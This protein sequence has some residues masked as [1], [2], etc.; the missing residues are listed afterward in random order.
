MNACLKEIADN[1]GIKKNLSTQ[2]T[3]HTIAT[4]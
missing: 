2:K 1:T 3:R 4:T